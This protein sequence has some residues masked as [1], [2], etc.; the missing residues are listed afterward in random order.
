VALRVR[1]GF[2]EVVVAGFLIKS[3]RS[4]VEGRG[5]VVTNKLNRISDEVI[6]VVSLLLR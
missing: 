6:I 5:D 4:V 1:I 2:G 3:R